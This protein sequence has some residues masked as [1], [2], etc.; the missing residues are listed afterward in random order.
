MLKAIFVLPMLVF[1][2]M[3]FGLGAVLFVPL[4][5]L[6]P[7]L[8]AVG[9][10]VAAVGLAVGLF[11]LVLRLC[12]AVFFGLGGLLVVGLGL[13][14]LMGGGFVAL[15]LGFTLAHL[16][17]PVLII[18]GLIWLIQRAARPAPSRISHNPG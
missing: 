7:V 17:L 2:A 13:F 3:L 18:V 11:A 10:C 8:L 16:L 14:F 1:G 15:A 12:A 4:L 5:A 6:L 9:A